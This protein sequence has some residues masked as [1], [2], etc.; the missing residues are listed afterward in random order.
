VS[1]VGALLTLGLK[2]SKNQSLEEASREEL[3]SVP[4][5]EK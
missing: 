5:V 3:V 1:V 2:E 4:V